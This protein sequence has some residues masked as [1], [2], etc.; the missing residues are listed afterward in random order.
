MV[1]VTFDTSTKQDDKNASN[2][3]NASKEDLMDS[4]SGMV[5]V[6]HDHEL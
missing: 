4:K 2:S 5:L 1:G 6:S 3:H